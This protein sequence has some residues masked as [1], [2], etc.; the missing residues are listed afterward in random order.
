MVMYSD[1]VLFMV[2]HRNYLMVFKQTMR[3]ISIF[4]LLDVLSD[5]NPSPSINSL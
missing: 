5:S 1:P 3:I 4:Y 2:E